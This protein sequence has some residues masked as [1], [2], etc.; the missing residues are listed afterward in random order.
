M[1]SRLPD[2]SEQSTG[3]TDLHLQFADERR[4][5]FLDLVDG[6]ASGDLLAVRVGLTEEGLEAG[7]RLGNAAVF[8]INDCLTRR[9]GDK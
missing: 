6:G 4:D 5:A 3:L 7:L 9:E 8:A 1:S 2:L